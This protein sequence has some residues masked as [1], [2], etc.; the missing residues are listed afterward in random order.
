MSLPYRLKNNVDTHGQNDMGV[1]K[2]NLTLEIFSRFEE[3]L[4]EWLVSPSPSL[5]PHPLPW[6][7]LAP[8]PQA[9]RSSA[10]EGGRWD[11][12]RGF[13]ET[14]GESSLKEKLD[15]LSRTVRTAR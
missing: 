10:A 2:F 5:K 1:A 4:K 7:V 11:E 15:K 14:D 9:G 8:P 12:G 13:D 3:Q 6:P